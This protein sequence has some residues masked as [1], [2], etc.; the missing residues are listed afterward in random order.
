MLNLFENEL[1]MLQ[2]QIEL[3]L[4]K[5]EMNSLQL[6]QRLAPAMMLLLK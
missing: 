4:T 5:F 3:K 6:N 2:N 1:N